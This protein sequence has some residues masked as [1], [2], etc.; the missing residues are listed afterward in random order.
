MAERLDEGVREDRAFVF[1]MVACGLIFVAQWPRLSREAFV[2]GAELQPLMGG[3]LM[4]WLLI[5]PLLCYALA[6]LSHL[7]AM[8]VGG[9]G[10]WF[11]ARLALFWSMLAVSPAWLLHGLTAG[12]VGPGPALS[13]VGAVLLTV[14]LWIWLNALLVAE[15]GEGEPA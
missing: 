3:A 12:F 4:G 14:F 11:G 2:T 1:L 8:A 13:L 7:A 9:R 15:R 10:T 6:A 5:A